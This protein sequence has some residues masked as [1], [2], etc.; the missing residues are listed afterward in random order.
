L[1]Q[2]VQTPALHTAA[3]ALH[4]LGAW[5]RIA[6]G[7]V[8]LGAGCSC[9]VASTLRVQDFEQQILDYLYEKHA[10]EAPVAGLLERTGYRPE[11]AGSIADLLAALARPE[12]ALPQADALLADLERSIG[13]FDAQHGAR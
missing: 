13:S 8:A 6:E 2:G 5:R 7:H 1:K 3:R 4:L 11:Q 12:G 9:G 10:A